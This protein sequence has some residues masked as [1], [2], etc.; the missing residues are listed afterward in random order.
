[1]PAAGCAC[2][3]M[4]AT[5]QR[6]AEEVAALRVK[7]FVL[8]KQNKVWK[9]MHQAASE[10]HLSPLASGLPCTSATSG[11]CKLDVLL[12]VMHT[13]T[14]LCWSCEHC[15][16]A[17][18]RC[19]FVAQVLAQQL[20]VVEEALAMAAAPLAASTGND[21][22]SLGQPAALLNP[23]SIGPAGGAACSTHTM[24]VF[25]GAFRSGA[26]CNSA[27]LHAAP[28]P[29]PE[30]AVYV[31]QCHATVLQHT[32][33]P[34]APGVAFPGSCAAAQVLSNIPSSSSTS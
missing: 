26:V 19:M 30:A 10:S 23:C 21:T 8:E 16:L 18:A 32:A 1:V 6:Q 20:K 27:A 29:P 5:C 34:S 22:S 4:E 31:E 13:Y 17:R 15:T 12:H 2:N 28:P 11:C 24:H 7:K 14:C 9:A 3:N 33:M 25:H